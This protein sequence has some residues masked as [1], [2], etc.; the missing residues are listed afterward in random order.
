MLKR[1]LC[2]RDEVRKPINHVLLLL[3]LMPMIQWLPYRNPLC[4]AKIL[5]SSIGLMCEIRTGLCLMSL[6]Y[7][8]TSKLELLESIA[9]FWIHTSFGSQPNIIYPH[10]ILY[11][12]TFSVHPLTLQ[13]CN[14][15]ASVTLLE[16]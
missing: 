15:Q 3:L 7:C 4:M 9:L 13:S 10:N 5:E 14:G 1:G 6:S 11:A 8:C 12:S 2:N 16:S